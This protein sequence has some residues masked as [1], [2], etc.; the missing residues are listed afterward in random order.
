MP[1][2]KSGLP[3]KQ[4]LSPMVLKS[5]RL[6]TPFVKENGRLRRASWEEAIE[7][8][9]KRMEG[10]SMAVGLPQL[11]VILQPLKKYLPSKCSVN[12]LAVANTDCRP[13]GDSLGQDGG[14]AGYLFNTTIAGNRSG[15]RHIADWI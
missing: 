4:D 12:I 8:I 5:Q 2:M 13:A 9:A 15:R 14:R 10:M 1:S 11:R 6:D 7:V 3:T